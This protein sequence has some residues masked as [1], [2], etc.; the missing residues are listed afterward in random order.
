VFGLRI[1]ETKSAFLRLYLQVWDG[2]NGSV[3]WEG[4]QEIISSRES[5]KEDSVPF[6]IAIEQSANEL[7]SRLP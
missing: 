5:L 4:A 2:E 7:I 1:V 3:V 6:K